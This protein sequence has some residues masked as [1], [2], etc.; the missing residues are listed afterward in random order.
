MHVL[1][2]ETD[3]LLRRALEFALAL[4]GHAVTM[5]ETDVAAVKACD[6]QTYPLMIVG[7]TSQAEGGSSPE[8]LCRTLRQLP[9]SERSTILVCVEREAASAI[10]AA[11]DAGADGYLARPVDA[12]QLRE[13]LELVERRHDDESAVVTPADLRNRALLEDGDELMLIVDGGGAIVWAA[14]TTERLLGCSS[15]SLSQES[16]YT[17]CHPDDTLAVLQLLTHALDGVPSHAVELRFQHRDQPWRTLEVRARNRLHD[18]RVGGILL[19]AHD[20]TERIRRERQVQRLGLHDPLTGLP[21][22]SLFQLYLERALARADRLDLPVAIMFLDLDDLGQVNACHGTGAGDRVLAETGRRLRTLLRATDTA[23]RVGDDEFTILLE[24]I[25]DAHEVVAIADRLVQQ[26]RTPFDVESISLGTDASIG[27]VFSEPGVPVAPGWSRAGELLRRA[28]V[29]LYR[30]KSAG[31][32]R[33]VLA[34]ARSPGHV[35]GRDAP[36]GR[37]A[38]RSGTGSGCFP[39]GGLPGDPLHDASSPTST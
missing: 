32:G 22:R 9:G 1:I 31:K 7:R 2:V 29:A 37:R 13:R 33:W 14:P 11:L 26:L 10:V 19:S 24:D 38:A 30:A 5:V 27:I 35:A 20:I 12:E 39:L 6:Q 16:I 36:V 17:L 28:D 8:A 21:I 18:P 3:A 4:S 15:A 23:A 25:A 34:D